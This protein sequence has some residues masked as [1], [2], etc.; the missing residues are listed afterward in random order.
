MFVMLGI[1]MGESMN[2]VFK[3]NKTTDYLG[4]MNA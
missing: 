3:S 2:L 1:K 4:D